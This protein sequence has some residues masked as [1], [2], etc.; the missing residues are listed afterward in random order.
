MAVPNLVQIRPWGATGKNGCNITIF[1]IYLYLSSWTHL[2]VR[3]VD[4]FSRLM[5]KTMWTRARMCLLGVSLISLFILGVKY[6]QNPNFGGM[7]R[8]FQ[9]KRAKYWKFHVIETTAS[10]LTKFGT[11]IE[12]IK[13]SS[14]VVPIGAQKIP[15]GGRPPFKKTVKSPYLCD[16]PILMKF[17]KAMD[18]HWPLAADQPLKFWIFKNPRRRW[19]PSWKITKIVISPQWFD[20]PLRNLVCWCKMGLLTSRLLKNWI[21]RIQDGWRS[22]FW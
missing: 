18:A 9:A 2:Q 10:I 22:P 14:C 17:G 1:F 5:A 16:R 6:P 19:P 4:G 20:W 3:P 8:R 21:S 12:T 15:D 7:N 13:W 11:M